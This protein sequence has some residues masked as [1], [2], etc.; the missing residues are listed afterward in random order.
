MSEHRRQFRAAA[1]RAADHA[2]LYLTVRANGARHRPGSF[3]CGDEV[4]GIRWREVI[5]NTAG[6]CGTDQGKRINGIDCGAQDVLDVGP[7]PDE[8]G[9]Q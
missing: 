5:E 9:I 6:E 2:R 1:P 8:I 7:E 4:H 3:A